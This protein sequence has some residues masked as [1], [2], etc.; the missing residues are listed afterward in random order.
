M[1]VY[2]GSDNDNPHI[3]PDTQK[4]MVLEMENGGVDME[5][6]VFNSASQALYAFLQVY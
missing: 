3:L 6:Y 5:S 4:F 1:Y 2:I